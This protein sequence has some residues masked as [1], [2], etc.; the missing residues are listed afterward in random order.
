MAYF[1]SNA[2]PGIVNMGYG[3]SVSGLYPATPESK[4]LLNKAKGISLIYPNGKA[5]CT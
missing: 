3:R 4:I 1:K 2:F 5:A